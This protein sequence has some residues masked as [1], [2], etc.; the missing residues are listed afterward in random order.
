MYTITPISPLAG[1][2]LVTALLELVIFLTKELQ[3]LEHKGKRSSLM[4]FVLLPPLFQE[5]TCTFSTSRLN[6]AF[7][8]VSVTRFPCFREQPLV[9]E[10]RGL[11]GNKPH[12][13]APRIGQLKTS[14]ATVHVSPR[15]I[16]CLVS[17]YL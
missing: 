2:P 17:N 3:P 8:F 15:C 10:Q 7:L 6:E 16:R 1:I 9:V 14:G 4:L 11:S 5:I 12:G 13:L